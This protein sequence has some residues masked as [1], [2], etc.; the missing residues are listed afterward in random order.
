MFLNFDFLFKWR[1]KG[2]V[3]LWFFL[4]LIWPS[5]STD[6][7]DVQILCHFT[8]WY[9][10][11]VVCELIFEKYNWFPKTVTLKYQKNVKRS[12]W[13]SPLWCQWRVKSCFFLLLYIF[14]CPMKV[15][16]YFLFKSSFNCA[17][18]S[19]LKLS[20]NKESKG[21]EPWPKIEQ[22]SIIFL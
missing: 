18:E 14:M 16:W 9:I 19:T 1:N 8:I 5:K 21:R 2:K 11:K 17:Y 15:L 13:P 6:D 3:I 12:K 4:F 10:L 20:H 7:S 22:K